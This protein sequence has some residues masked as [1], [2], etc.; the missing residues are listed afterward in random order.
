MKA[1]IVPRSSAERFWPSFGPLQVNLPWIRPPRLLWIWVAPTRS[2][3]TIRARDFFAQLLDGLVL[4]WTAMKLSSPQ[5]QF[6]Q[7]DRKLGQA[8]LILKTLPHRFARHCQNL[9]LLPTRQKSGARNSARYW[10]NPAR[11]TRSPSGIFSL[12]LTY[13]TAAASMTGWQR[14]FRLPPES[15][16]MAFCGSTKT[17]STCGGTNWTW[18]TSPCATHRN[19]HGLKVKPAKNNAFTAR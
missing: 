13:R 17:C 9:I 18:E 11:A 15:L 16:A 12:A 5:G 4:S 3:W 10:R 2:K 1:R 8:R 19:M 7:Q 14:S 6:A